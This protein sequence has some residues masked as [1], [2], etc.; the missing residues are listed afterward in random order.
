MVEPQLEVQ[1]TVERRVGLE[2]RV[3]PFCKGRRFFLRERRSAGV[4]G[5]PLERRGGAPGPDTP[6]V[7]VTPR[8]ARDVTVS[9]RR[10]RTDTGR[11]E[12]QR[13][14]DQRDEPHREGAPSSRS[15]MHGSA[16]DQ[17]QGTSNAGSGGSFVGDPLH[18]VR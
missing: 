3:E 13:C 15:P 2:T 8:C 12:E 17:D 16:R 18:N 5:R 11:H 7:R 9:R 10:L 14:Q 1:L 4:L 6:K